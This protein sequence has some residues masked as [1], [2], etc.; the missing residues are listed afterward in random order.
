MVN[1]TDVSAKLY[2]YFELNYLVNH[3]FLDLLISKL[4]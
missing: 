4:R 3:I 1:V 2:F